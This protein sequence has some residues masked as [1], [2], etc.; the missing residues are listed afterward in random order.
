MTLA[1]LQASARRK[2]SFDLTSSGYSDTNLNASL[3]EW[4]RVIFGWALLASG[5]WE[6]GGEMY[7]TDLVADQAEYVLPTHL[8]YLNRVEVKYPNATSY[9]LAQRVDD[10]E[11]AS[12][13]QNAEI[14]VGT[15]DYP[16]YRD[17]D[18]SIF[19]YPVPTD[20]VTAGL[21]IEAA[22][23]VTDLSGST[24][25]P[26]LNPL[27]HRAVAIGGAYDYALSNGMT[28]KARYLIGEI[29][30]FPGGSIENTLKA[31]IE[32]LAAIK[33]NGVRKQLHVR[34]QNWR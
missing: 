25:L 12:A 34:T 2:I 5:V 29:Q 8:V 11:T 33:D 3:N 10:K 31:Q 24:D 22:I 20:A 23:D 18:S 16:R 28:A 19:L 4:Y 27:I 17:F 9:V 30:G 14:D 26:D 21:A 6:V 7:T 15:T 1:E 32:K 13:F